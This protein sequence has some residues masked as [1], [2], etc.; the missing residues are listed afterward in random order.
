MII[1]ARLWL[2]LLSASIC[3]HLR[4]SAFICVHLRLVISL[5]KAQGRCR[6]R[7]IIMPGMV[8]PAPDAI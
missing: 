4:S 5:R 6:L 7:P 8:S 1:A 3:V 2:L